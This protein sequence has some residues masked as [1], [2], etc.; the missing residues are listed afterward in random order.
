M[1][2]AKLLDPQP[3]PARTDIFLH[4]LDARTLESLRRALGQGLAPTAL[5]FAG[6]DNSIVILRFTRPRAGEARLNAGAG[7]V[8]GGKPH[9]VR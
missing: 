4:H 3:V 9:R 7:D 8:V 1:H 6:D 5:D 2:H